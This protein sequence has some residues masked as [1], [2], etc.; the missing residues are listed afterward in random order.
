M[1]KH[2]N[3]RPKVSKR[4]TPDN[5]DSEAGVLIRLLYDDLVLVEVGAAADAARQVR[6]DAGPALHPRRKDL[7]TRAGS[8]GAG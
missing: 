5:P 7:G 3:P 4:P 8:P 6:Q 2:R 1:S